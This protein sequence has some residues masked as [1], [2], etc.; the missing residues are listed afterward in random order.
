M[1]L[2]QAIKHG[3]EKRKLYRGAKARDPWCRNH[4]K[5]WICR[6]NRLHKGRI[7]EEEIKHMKKASEYLNGEEC[8]ES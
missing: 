1:S 8:S 4:G 3:K 2:D 6:E 5:C 7:T